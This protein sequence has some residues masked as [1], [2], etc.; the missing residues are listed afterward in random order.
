MIKSLNFIHTTNIFEFSI[1]KKNRHSISSEI[2]DSAG[3]WWIGTNKGVFKFNPHKNIFNNIYLSDLTDIRK[4]DFINKASY[5]DNKNILFIL[6]S[7]KILN[8][9]SKERSIQQLKLKYRSDD[10]QLNSIDAN[11][12]GD[13]LVSTNDGLILLKGYNSNLESFSIE[14]KL[15]NGQFIYA[16]IFDLDSI[17]VI[18]KSGVFKINSNNKSLIEIK[19]LSDIVAKQ[20]VVAIKCSDK[21]LWIQQNQRIIEYDK[22]TKSI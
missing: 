1:D 17:W 18:G 14:E 20:S 13:Q 22:K 6:N 21:Y 16:A 19:S 9:N 10:I 15:L 2:I 4:E 8:F 7:G 5:I 3:I 12:S 11:K